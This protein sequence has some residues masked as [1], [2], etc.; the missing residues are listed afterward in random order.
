[1]ADF[2]VLRISDTGAGWEP[3]NTP[4]RVVADILSAS[5]LV[6]PAGSSFPVSPAAGEW[7]WRT[8]I[9]TLYRRN[10][11]NTAWEAVSATAD[12]GTA[13]FYPHGF[14]NQTD[15]SIS[16][17][18]GTRTFTISTVSG[19]D[20]YWQGIKIHKS[21]SENIVISTTTGLHFIY[22]ATSSGTLTESTTP[23][24]LQ[25]HIPI[26]LVYWNNTT[27]V[28]FLAEERHLTNLPWSAHYY[29]HTTVG[30]RYRTGLA[31][32]GYTLDTDTDAA[33]TFAVSTGG[34]MDEDISITVTHA[35]TPTNE[36]EQFIN[37]PAKLPVY[38]RSGASGD[39]VRDTPT[40]F[41]FKNVTGGTAR[42]AFNE[43]TG[44]AWQQTELNNANYCAYWIF[45]TDFWL[46]PIIS[47]QGQRQDNNLA[48]AKA[49]NTLD[50]LDLG[51]LPAAE[52]KLLYRIIVRSDNGFGGTRKAKLMD[53]VD[54]RAVSTVP[55]SYIPVSHASLGDLSTSGHP[56]SVVS[57]DT[58]NFDGILS[59]ADT[60]V[61][62]A[63][64]TIDNR[65]FTGSST[66]TS[67]TNGALWY[68]S[69]SGWECLMQYD[70]SRSKWLS[71][72]EWALQWGH[73]TADGELLRG[74]GVNVPATDTGMLIPRNACVKRIS[75]RTRT[76]NVL[77]RI[78]IYVNG[79]SALNFNLVD[80]TNSSVYTNNA[81]NL[82]LSEN[83]YLW[84]YVDSALGG[85]DDVAVCLWCSWRVT[86]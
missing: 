12:L 86:P 25:T 45:A 68:N 47:V 3:V 66:P 63:L 36:F 54:Y 1:M 2:K 4:D 73:D 69:T 37:D 27:G 74:F 8:D 72:A 55:G 31:L 42:V 76:D 50:S 58:T 7:F 79:A 19:F 28:G 40:D 16:F 70:A 5:V 33:V 48:N 52:M 65:I 43:Y 30:T 49:N 85:I 23:W 10:S 51:T 46:N 59:S 44:G 14:V 29:L 84:V 24:D 22:Y 78:D 77:K 18:D 6:A 83:D 81:T 34:V 39:W 75:V 64:E 41:C 82:N 53:I 20:V 56:A 26:A 71:V 57:T 80:G 11:T 35:A 67:T 15:S 21:S 61:Q 38:Y 13:A 60:T 9:A 17:V 32:S 62:S